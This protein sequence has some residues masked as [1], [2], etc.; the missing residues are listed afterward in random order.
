[1]TAPLVR[2]LLLAVLVGG[3][4]QTADGAMVTPARP[5]KGQIRPRGRGRGTSLRRGANR[6]WFARRAAGDPEARRKRGPRAKRWEREGDAL[7]AENTADPSVNFRGLSPAEQRERAGEMLAAL[8]QANGAEAAGSVAQPA[9]KT[10]VAAAPGPPSTVMWGSCSVGP[11]LKSRLLAAEMPTPLPIQEAAFGPISRGENVVIGSATGSGKTLAFLLPLLTTCSRDTPSRI[12]VVTPSAELTRQLRRDV[13]LLWPPSKASAV[14]IVGEVEAAAG[15]DEVA[16]ARAELKRIGD[17]PILVGQPYELR[18]LMSAAQRA[19]RASRRGRG[20]GRGGASRG[21]RGRGGRGGYYESSQ[22]RGAAS[23]PRYGEAS[24]GEVEVVD[25]EA[26]LRARQLREHLRVVV[27]DEADALLESAAYAKQHMWRRA[28]TDKQGASLTSRQRAVLKQRSRRS[29]TEELLSDL[30]TPLKEL[31]LVCA[32]ATVGR[33]LRRQLQGL[34]DAPSIDKATTLI[35]AGGRDSKAESVR[36]AALMPQTLTHCFKLVDTDQASAAA[37]DAAVDGGDGGDGAAEEA[38]EEEVAPSTST[39]GA[40]D[41][42]A[43]LCEAMGSLP[44]APAIVFAGSVGVR[45]VAEALGAAGLRE[46]KLMQT[47]GDGEDGG[48]GVSAVASS[49]ASDAPLA[50]WAETPVYVGSERWGRGVDLEVGYVFMLAPPTSSATYAHLA[51]RT[52]RKGRAGTA[53]TLLTHVQ[54]PRLVAVASSLGLSF[55]PVGDEAAEGGAVAEAVAS[56]RA[57][58]APE[59]DATEDVELS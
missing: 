40:S 16:M 36:R 43:A 24:D 39:A 51:G 48:E 30:P 28:T 12:L 52:G 2:W 7:Y 11:V 3:W 17:A 20:R 22:R 53:V 41:L 1:M 4:L 42:M 6:D 21:G 50:A 8:A 44:V 58:S 23:G 27:I 32:S 29:A 13:D 9:E 49:D 37:D 57:E 56:E 47:A 18:R 46:V 5:A 26:T 14:H 54:A 38:A 34:L 25:E 19:L 45:P 15:A 10:P 31:Q 33:S 59:E 55:T 35:S